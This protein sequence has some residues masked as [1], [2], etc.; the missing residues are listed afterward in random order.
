MKIE[1]LGICP[2]KEKDINSVDIN[3]IQSDNNKIVFNK[4]KA[5]TCKFLNYLIQNIIK[6][7][8]SW[9]VFDSEARELYM[10]NTGTM[11]QAT[12]NSCLKDLRDNK[13]IAY[14]NV[15]GYFWINSNII[16]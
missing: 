9:I 14:T 11:H 5:P 12:V 3:I 2:F 10:K 16:R 7:G 15:K 8:D 13:V 1:T 4:L 6:K